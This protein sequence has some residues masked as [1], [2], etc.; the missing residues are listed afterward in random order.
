MA[1]ASPVQPDTARPHGQARARRTSLPVFCLAALSALAAG[2]AA[3]PAADTGVSHRE[4]PDHIVLLRQG[5][6][7]PAMR[8][9]DHRGGAFTRDRLPGRWTILFFGYTHCPDYCPATLLAL[10]GAYRQLEHE[11][12]GLAGRLQ[13]VFV[14]L[15]PFRDTPAVLADYLAYFNPRFIGAT[16]LP[17]DLKRLATVLGANYSYTDSADGRRIPDTRRQPARDYAVN[18]S[19]SLYIFDDRARLSA[20]L[21]PPLTGARIDALFT[22]IR[23]QDGAR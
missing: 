18:H 20:R 19:A 7:A 14:S 12:A 3:L 17:A 21:A 2:C 6:P 9:V 16:G 23:Q 4:A 22:R 15:D 5:A 10:N 1:Q 13:V 11:D 8:L